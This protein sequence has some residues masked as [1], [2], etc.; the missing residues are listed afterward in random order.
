MASERRLSP[1]AARTAGIGRHA[2]GGS[3]YLDVLTS[4]SR[5]W[6]YR[7]RFGGKVKDMSLGDANVI[8]LAD[9]RGL[10]DKWRRKLTLGFDPIESRRAEKVVGVTFAEIVDQVLASDRIKSLSNAKHRAQW[11]YC[12]TELSAPLRPRPVADITTQ[13]ILAVLKPLWA[14]GKH[15]TASRLRSRI[16]L[17]IEVARS[18]HVIADDKPN[19]A[20]W[21]KHIELHAP[22]TNAV[23]KHHAALPYRDA[24]SF[25]VWLRSKDGVSARALEWT[26][27]TA[28]RTGETLSATA[29]EIDFETATWTIPAGRMKSRRPHRVP[30]CERALE[31]AKEGRG[32]PFL[33]PGRRGKPLSDTAMAVFLK[34]FC[35]PSVATPHGFRS[36]FD[37][38]AASVA[39]AERGVIERCLAHAV[40]GETEAAYNRSDLLERR[41]PL[42]EKWAAYLHQPK[43]SLLLR[44]SMVNLP[45]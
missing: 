25:M 16:E 14:D 21:S 40:R 31:I 8:T 28:C 19:V 15:A 2:D 24:P 17:V 44:E 23:K 1:N 13:D 41:R 29:A 6:L 11:R 4:G 27:L 37:Q 12:L 10:R 32:R 43:I 34:G 35:A 39:H 5:R 38:W 20:R 22:R 9:A 26:I 7:Y 33:F 18:Q 42:M 45:T 3:L 30:L 36:T